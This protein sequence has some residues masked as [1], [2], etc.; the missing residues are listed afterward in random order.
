[1]KVASS[2]LNNRRIVTRFTQLARPFTFGLS[3]GQ[4]WTAP[5]C[6]LGLENQDSAREILLEEFAVEDL[7]AAGILERISDGGLRLLPAYGRVSGPMIAIH[8]VDKASP[9]SLLTRNNS[10]SRCGEVPIFTILRDRPTLELLA[11]RNGLL[12]LAPSLEQAAVFRTLGLAAAPFCRIQNLNRA[13]LERL[14]HSV[15]E[16]GI[17]RQPTKAKKKEE[18]ITT[19]DGDRV[20]IQAAATLDEELDLN[21]IG[22][23]I[24]DNYEE[25]D[26]HKRRKKTKQVE[27]DFEC[28]MLLTA[29]NPA[30]NSDE[31]VLQVRR[32]AE[33]FGRTSRILNI[34]FCGLGVWHPSPKEHRD[35]EFAIKRGDK[36]S[37]WRVVRDSTESSTY[38][39]EA[40]A[41][42]DF[43]LTQSPTDYEGALQLLD[44][45]IEEGSRGESSE[46]RWLG[47]L[48]IF[49]SMVDR[50][51]VNPLIKKAMQ[52]QDPVCRTLYGLAGETV[53]ILHRQI[54]AVRKQLSERELGRRGGQDKDGFRDLE[55]YRRNMNELLRIFKTLKG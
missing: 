24:A 23:R 33:F 11:N 31:Q 4:R 40:F 26:R 28:A 42:P 41:D 35:L 46:E 18:E 15:A 14:A 44:R 36:E 8:T 13:G 54:P 38:A 30:G 9:D 45:V 2:N 39:V 12:F 21:L 6:I 49:G 32:L 53:R 47:C 19:P 7:L 29:W 50:D 43:E 5:G 27:R 10:R 34:E 20:S 1:M 48:R 51:L 55:Q 16:I 22:L 25:L 52:T 3:G 17:S 37:L